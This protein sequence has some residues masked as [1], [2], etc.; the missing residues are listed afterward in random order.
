MRG[1]RGEYTFRGINH[2]KWTNSPRPPNVAVLIFGAVVYNGM[3]C[4]RFIEAKARLRT[5]S[6]LDTTDSCNLLLKYVAGV[7]R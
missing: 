3:R 7:N 4:S 6:Q 5:S 2:S 1:N